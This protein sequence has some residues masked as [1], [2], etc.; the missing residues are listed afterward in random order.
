MDFKNMKKSQIKK[1]I[2]KNYSNPN[3]PFAFSG[4]NKVYNYVG[5]AL[6]KDEIKTILLKKES[7]TLMKQEINRKK[8]KT[9]TPITAF[10]FLDNVQADLIDV[11]RL[12]NYNNKVNFLFCIIDVFSRYGWIFPLQ[13]KKSDSILNVLEYFFRLNNDKVSNI[14]FDYGGE[15]KNTKVTSFKKKNEC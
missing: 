10:H 9:F 14:S 15:F 5:K 3:C 7:Y 11:S 8:N 2:E 4:I 13:N 6:N 12:S 1:Y